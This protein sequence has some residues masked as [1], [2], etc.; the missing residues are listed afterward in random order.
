[1]NEHFELDSS[2]VS[3]STYVNFVFCIFII[4]FYKNCA[5]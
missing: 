4:K 5:A 2:L 1:M 3:L